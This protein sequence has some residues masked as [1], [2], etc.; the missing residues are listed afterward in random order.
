MASQAALGSR[1]EHF[2]LL[3]PLAVVL[4]PFLL[5]PLLLGLLDSFADFGVPAVHIQFVGLKNYLALFADSE[6]SASWRNIF[7]F[8]IV[9]VPLE[10]ILG[11]GIAYLLRE[12]FRGRA[13]L[14]IVLLIPWLV[15][16]IANGVMWHFLF[17]LQWGIINYFPAWFGVSLPSPFA[18]STFALPAT[19]AT[20][21]WRNA[22]LATF[23]LL[24]GL[25]AIP[26]A[27]WEYPLLEGASSL[28]R[29]RYVVLPWLR[30]L[31]L[32]VALLLIGGTLGTSD[33]ILIL[34]GG[35][36]GSATMTPGLYSYL[37][38]FQYQSWSLG[39]TAAWL[40]VASLLLVG[41]IYL[42]LTEGEMR[43]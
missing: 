41:I 34:T 11:L 33:S 20:D 13:M 38:A 29:L 43:G 3:I 37:Q 21:V 1:R 2:F 36:P 8:C 32:A 18:S 9:A 10:L 40:I 24:P 28:A 16:P 19:I 42:R 14:R 35:G 22:P 39:A 31:L 12:P 17:N 5:V 25:L 15:S 30:P 27:Q 26:A 23:L 7:V 6:F 4:I